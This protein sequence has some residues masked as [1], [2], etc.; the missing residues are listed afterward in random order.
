MDQETIAVYQAQCAKYEQFAVTESQARAMAVFADGL[1]SGGAIFDLGCGPGVQGAALVAQG[2]S[3]TGLEPAPAFVEAARARGLRVQQ[4]SFEDISETVAYDGLWASFSL[5]HAPRVDFQRYLTA[6]VK[7]VR[8]GGRVFLG[9][10]TG[11]GERRDDLG[12]FYTFYTVAELTAAL[13]E[14]GAQVVWQEEGKEPGLAGSVDP[15]VHMVA[16]RA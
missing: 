8:P 14:A 12:R 3:V 11:V 7:T 15:F 5:L 10:K 6:A 13:A 4:G 2:F 9:M 1:Q 16:Q